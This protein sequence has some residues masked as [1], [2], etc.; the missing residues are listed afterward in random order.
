MNQRQIEKKLKQLNRRIKLVEREMTREI[1]FEN[2]G[3][4]R[5]LNEYLERLDREVEYF[6]DALD[7]ITAKKVKA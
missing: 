5:L 3:N 6:E 1:K 4:A 2:R 7:N